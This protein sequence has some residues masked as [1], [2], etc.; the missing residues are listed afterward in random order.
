MSI[1][2]AGLLLDTHVLLWAVNDDSRL[3]DRHREVIDRRQGLV[4]SVASIWEIA[5]KRSMKRLATNGDVLQAIHRS[6]VRLLPITEQHALQVEH[7]PFHH[8]DPFDRM[9]IAQAQIEG[10]TLLTADKKFASYDIA[11]M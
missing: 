4:V 9:L 3:S 8:R 11:V 1:E 7:L 5:I 10:L 2:P 6:A